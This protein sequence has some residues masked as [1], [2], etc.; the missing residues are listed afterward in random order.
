LNGK[1]VVQEMFDAIV[2]QAS[3]RPNAEYHNAAFIA[4]AHVE[5]CQGHR[6]NLVRFAHRPARTRT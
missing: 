2:E 6:A 1:S 5:V 4:Y 3:S